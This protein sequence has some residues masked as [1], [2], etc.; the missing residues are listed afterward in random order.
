VMTHAS[1]KVSFVDTVH[2]DREPGR[3]GV[4]LY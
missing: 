2:L 1:N 3:R 4:R